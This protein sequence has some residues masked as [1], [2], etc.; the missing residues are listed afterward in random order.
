MDAAWFSSLIE[1]LPSSGIMKPRRRVKPLNSGDVARDFTTDKNN[2][3][4][5]DETQEGMLDRETCIQ[6]DHVLR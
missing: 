6:V 4:S 3:S 2:S 5:F 1:E